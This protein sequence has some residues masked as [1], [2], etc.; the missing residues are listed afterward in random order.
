V[1]LA[2]KAELADS[3]DRWFIQPEWIAATDRDQYPLE[4]IVR[5][6]AQEPEP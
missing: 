4:R 3:T 6:D 2:G 5:G 1:F